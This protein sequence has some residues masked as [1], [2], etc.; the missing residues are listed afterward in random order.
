MHVDEHTRKKQIMYVSEYTMQ[1]LHEDR[2]RDAA[3]RYAQLELIRDAS[4]Q[5]PDERQSG[6]LHQFKQLMHLG[7]RVQ[8]Q[9]QDCNDVR[10][11]H[12]I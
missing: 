4:E 8:T 3:K 7:N 5:A 6:L 10:P 2:L 9:P 11:A 1:L 12:A